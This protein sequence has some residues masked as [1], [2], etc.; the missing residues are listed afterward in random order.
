[1]HD[2]AS[3]VV[4]VRAAVDIA[5]TSRNNQTGRQRIERQ[6]VA[7]VLIDWHAGDGHYAALIEDCLEQVTVRRAQQRRGI[8][9]ITIVVVVFV[10]AY[11]RQQADLVLLE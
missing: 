6:S 2:V 10:I 7:V 5:A 1:M 11:M 4:L 9:V 3:P 8:I